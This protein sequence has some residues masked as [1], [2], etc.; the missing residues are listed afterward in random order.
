[1]KT[2]LFEPGTIRRLLDHLVMV[3]KGV[4]ADPDLRLSELP[5]LTEREREKL[6]CWRGRKVDYPR[7]ATLNQI[8][9]AQAERTPDHVAV[10]FEDRSLTYR[11]LNE[12]ANRLAHYLRKFRIRPDALVGVLMDRS[13]EMIVALLGILKSGGGY[14]PLD[15]AYPE[16]RLRFMV[17]D[18]CANLI[19]AQGDCADFLADENRHVIRLDDD[20]PAIAGLDPENP[21]PVASAENI[22]YVNYTS[23]STGTPKGVAVPHRAVIRLV[24]NT[25][26]FTVEAA[27]VFLHLSSCAFDATTFE[28]W[29]AL[30]NG[31]RCVIMPGQIPTTAELRRVIGQHGV[32]VLWLTA[33]LF[34]AIID[35][36]PAA[37]EGVR[38]LL[39]GGEALSVAHVCLGQQRLPNAQI[40]NGYGP[41]EGTTFSC[42][43][44]IPPGLDPDIPSIP[45]GPPIAN[46]EAYVLDPHGQLLP[47]GIPGELFI[48]GDG[49]ARGYLNRPELTAERFVPN[50]FS[51]EPCARLYRT[52]DLVRFLPD[53][54]LEFLGRLDGQVKIHGFRIEPGEIEAV[55]RAQDT[56]RQAAVIVREDT[57]GDK[58]LVAYIVPA[59]GAEV[60]VGMLRDAL[61]LRLPPYMIPASFVFLERL[62]LTANGKLDRRAL[63]PP[64]KATMKSM[65]TYTPPR[66]P[67]ETKLVK[68]WS[69]ILGVE[70][71]SVR[72]NFFDLGGHSLKALRVLARI[73]E[74]F[75]L[76]LPVRCLFE[77]QTISKLAVVIEDSGGISE[78]AAPIIPA[79]RD[80]EIPQ[81]FGQQGLWF[82]EQLHPGTAQYNVPLCIRLSGQLNAAVLEDCL[83]EV[84]RRHEILRTTFDAVDGRPVQIIHDSSTFV[85]RIDD[86]QG[87]PE[88]QR[89]SEAQSRIVEEVR[90]PFDLV[91][92]PL[93]R[94]RLL[95]LKE[96]EHILI[97]IIHHI[98]CDGWSFRILF[99]EL[100]A[101]YQARFAV[102]LNPLPEL[103][104]QYADFAYWQ[105]QRLQEDLIE[106]QLSYWKQLMAGVPT[107]L[108]LPS[109]RK[110]PAGPAHA[111]ATR[112][113]Q[114]PRV[115]L[116]GLQALSRQEGVSLFMTILA[117]FQTLLWKY[118]GF[119][120]IVVGCPLAGRTILQV[121]RLIGYFVNT[122]P[123][124]ANLAGDS[125]FLELLTTTRELTLGAYAH[126]D[127]PLERLV[128]E[129]HPERDPG[130]TPLFQVV[131]AFENFPDWGLNVPGLTADFT[132]VDTGT[133]KFDLTLIVKEH[134]DGLR[135]SMEYRTVLFEPVTIDWMLCAFQTL[136]EGVL[137]DPNQRLTKLAR[138]IPTRRQ[139]TAKSQV[140]P[141]H[142]DNFEESEPLTDVEK[143]LAGMWSELLRRPNV[144][145]NQDFFDLG[146]DSLLAIRLFS[147]VEK[148]FGVTLPLSTL[149]E[150]A[151]VAT[152]AGVIESRLCRD[153]DSSLWTIR[154]GFEGPSLYILPSLGGELM[155]CR[156]LIAELGPEQ[157]VQGF[158]TPGHDTDRKSFATIEAM[159][160]YFAEYLLRF[161]PVGPYCL[162]GYSFGGTV[163]YE[164]A[165]QLSAAG[166][167][168]ALLALIDASTFPV[169]EGW[170]LSECLGG[171]S[172][173]FRNLPFW[174]WGEIFKNNPRGI[175]KHFAR[176]SK[177]IAR[178]L[179]ALAAFRFQASVVE[180][181]DEIFDV[182]MLSQPYRD[183]MQTHLR[184]YREYRAQPYR[185]RVTLFR[186]RIRP[187]THSL[188]YDLGWSRMALG[189]VD[190]RVIPC[191]HDNI[192][193][194]PHV[195]AISRQIRNLLADVR[196]QC[197]IANNGAAANLDTEA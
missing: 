14:L 141:R 23:G 155:F 150:S 6:L 49:L 100:A 110:A 45:I 32:T 81:S 90:L 128:K 77:S 146:G 3:L 94:A 194:K 19:L 184:A 48:G 111:G 158:H 103:P 36:D 16:Q 89:S 116:E 85:L 176:G 84:I 133:A 52:G 46:S 91:S 134:N 160:Q 11:Q 63:P 168:V 25:N 136:L 33:S 125:S 50:P 135:L 104:I 137:K 124:P 102:L 55:L 47:A 21:A 34:N 114:L 22:A 24:I 165:R 83:N 57:P 54:V 109:D 196:Q 96:Q 127:L 180:D 105:G 112:S 181:L 131:L 132:E 69:D 29:G 44:R 156:E 107:V 87:L 35:E 142:V 71:V 175:A 93:L 41:T 186:A 115:L 178:R 26:Y 117:A 197:G 179:R 13:L 108:R 74:A 1:Y 147:R 42:C 140:H 182:S 164:L 161:Q 28:V 97:L 65:D 18:A 123:F 145:L 72:D 163:A 61:S 30:L 143:T 152:L 76:E 75:G 66:T 151:T 17:E 106:P 7:E 78:T 149:F 159:A 39:T 167:E 170:D 139:G 60:S 162:L 79:K 64:D 169:T 188:R 191:N 2:D 5:L 56:I 189:G 148:N 88:L 40:I 43:Y 98:V 173:F 53:G 12:R 174:V 59:A 27:D 130:S 166:R 67:V 37:L 154:T 95:R 73:H 86:L 119:E 70:S 68:I 126:Q 99:D 120:K 113:I 15:R 183:I 82:L 171:I 129:L 138:H 20:W 195:L 38:Q 8:F 51:V 10:V 190:I 92:G 121:E 185:G 122:L 58:H 31:A 193:R 144:G 172:G 192:M 153:S 9:E 177:R 157:M 187:L 80:G 118:T 62:P 101:L 4:T